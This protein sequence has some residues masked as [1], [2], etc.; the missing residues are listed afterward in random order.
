MPR[1]KV[2]DERCD[3]VGFGGCASH[4]RVRVYAGGELRPVVVVSECDDNEGTSIT[5]CAECLYPRVIARHL[6]G[7]LDQAEELTL[8][9][10]YPGLAGRAGRRG[11]D[12]FDVVRF[13]S[14]RPRI[15]R[16]TGRPVVSFGA[17]DWRPLTP[18]A[19]ADLIG[20]W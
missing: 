7:W 10:H 8:I 3:Y 14:W 1:R 4:C 9:E 12:Q 16:A 11:V 15:E 13:A 2:V 5:N 17:P 20:E 18:S 19:V 6:P